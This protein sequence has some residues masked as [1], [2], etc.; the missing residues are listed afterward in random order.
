MMGSITLDI[1]SYSLGAVAMI[2]LLHLGCHNFAF[3]KTSFINTDCDT[4]KW[5]KSTA[6]FGCLTWLM[7]VLESLVLI[8]TPAITGNQQNI[9]NCGII[10]YLRYALFHWSKVCSCCFLIANSIVTCNTIDTTPNLYPFNKF[11][12][13][14]SL[15]ALVFA[16]AAGILDYF[17][18]FESLKITSYNKWCVFYATDGFFIITAGLV[19]FVTIICVLLF[20]IPLKFLQKRSSNTDIASME[21]NGL[22]LE[23]AFLVKKYYFLTITILVVEFLFLITIIYKTMEGTCNVFFIYKY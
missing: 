7:C 6:I 11:T 23:L 12:Y 5:G 13:P 17:M 2:I 16:I 8:L 20:I 18:I 9:D 14:L 15:I 22:H 3:F 19:I 1:G 10:L 21:N 4:I